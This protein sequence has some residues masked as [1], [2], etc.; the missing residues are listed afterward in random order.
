[1]KSMNTKTLIITLCL[2][3]VF[4]LGRANELNECELTDEYIEARRE[5]RKEAVEITSDYK[6]CKGAS[7]SFVFWK[8]MAR[9]TEENAGYSIGGGCAHIVSQGSYPIDEPDD[10][11]CE[12]F[13]FSN[14]E[15]A[16][17]A[18]ALLEDKRVKKC[19]T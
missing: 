17:I 16:R 12:H 14:E 13:K 19:K 2:L 6:H 3:L 11:H 18:V 1:M 7:R 15:R 9:C 4:D 5:A 10:L 8:A